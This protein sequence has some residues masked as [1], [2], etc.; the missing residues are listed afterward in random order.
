MLAG[1]SLP[2]PVYFVADKY[3]ASGR[4]MKQLIGSGIHIITMMKKNAV[5][6]YLP[7][8]ENK[9]RGRPRKYGKSIKLF[10]LFNADLSFTKAPMPGNPSITIEY[11]VVELFWKPLG[12]LAKFVLVRHPEKGNSI[13]MSTDRSLDPMDIILGYSLRFKIEV[14][15]KQAVHQIGAFMYRFWL[16]AMLPKKRG[17][18]D[19]ALQFAPNDFKEKI[20]KKLNAYHLFIQLG[21]IAHGLMQYLSIHNHQTVWKYFGTWL[22]TIR[23]NTLP[24]EKVVALALSR[25]YI[26]FLIDDTIGCIF[27]KFLRKRADISQLQHGNFELK[28]LA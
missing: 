13:P 22:R 14:M 15:F 26:E 23:S 21:F 2:V 9:R 8:P 11:C 6:Y 3:Y 25:T 18:G 27:K 28:H 20:A 5:A 19:L 17:S 1:L 12:D 16:K 7:E 10:E 24:S 4:F